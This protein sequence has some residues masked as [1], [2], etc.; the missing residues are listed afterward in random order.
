MAVR[1]HLDEL[2]RLEDGREGL[3]LI[4]VPSL[5][6]SLGDLVDILGSRQLQELL[7]RQEVQRE[8]LQPSES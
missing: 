1:G 8:S 3:D 4:L 7:L 5:L 6:E 2:R